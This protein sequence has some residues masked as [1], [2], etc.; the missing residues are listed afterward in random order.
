MSDN[1]TKT[2]VKKTFK[3]CLTE[4]K[5]YDIVNKLSARDKLLTTNDKNLD[6]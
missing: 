2:K 4:S 1:S 3:K 5:Q 6:N